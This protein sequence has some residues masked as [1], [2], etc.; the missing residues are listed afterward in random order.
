MIE[1]LSEIGNSESMEITKLANELKR[2]GK[3]VIIL[4]IGDSYFHP[5]K[6]IISNATKALLDGKTHYVDSKGIG[7][8]RNKISIFYHDGAYNLDENLILPGTKQ[9]LFYLLSSINKQRVCVFT[10]MWLGYGSLIKITGK[11]PI[12]INL[13]EENWKKNLKESNFDILIMNNPNNPDGKVFSKDE[14][15]FIVELARNKNVHIISDEIY[16]HFCYTKK[17]LTLSKYDYKNIHIVNGFSKAYGMSGLR[18]GYLVSKNKIIV[19][20]VNQLQQHISTCTNSVAQYALRDFDKDKDKI[21]KIRKYYLENRNIISEIIPEF[22][23]FIP[24]GGFYLFADLDKFGV[25]NSVKFS[26][27]LLLEDGVSVVPGISYGEDFQSWIRISICVHRDE[28]T[29]GLELIKRRLY[30]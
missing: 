21:E 12:F 6:K 3:D 16:R 5:P 26:K 10:P 24:D 11:K 9:A 19:N 25:S 18:I 4:S 23:S 8:L 20:R 30:R 1:N 7:D 15:E 28:L 2:K 17:H 14:I 22:K 27:E 13:R 29:R